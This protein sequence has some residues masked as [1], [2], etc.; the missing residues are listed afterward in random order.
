IGGDIRRDLPGP[1]KQ[2]EQ[3][4]KDWIKLMDRAVGTKYVTSLCSGTELTPV[5]MEIDKILKSC[6]LSLDRYLQDKREYFPRFFFVSTTVLLDILSKRTDPSSIKNNLCIIFDAINDIEF[7]EMDRRIIVKIMQCKSEGNYKDIQIVDLKEYFVKCEGKIED[8]LNQLVLHMQKSIKAIFQKAYS[9]YRQLY[10]GE[11]TAFS[12]YTKKYISQV[13]I[14]G[15]M[16]YGTKKL[17]EFVQRTSIEKG[18]TYKKKLVEARN[19]GNPNGEKDPVDLEFINIQE[20]L[21]VLCREPHSNK[22]EVVKLETLIIIHV[23]SRDIFDFILKQ[24]DHMVTVTDYDWLKQSRVYWLVSHQTCIIN[25]TDVPFEYG[26]EFLGAKERL[27]ITELTDKCYITLAQALGMNYGGA[28]AGPA[29]TGKTE[30]VKDMG[31]TMG[32][33]VLVTNC[34]PEH[35]YKNMVQIFKGLCRAGAW[36]CFDEFNRIFLDVLSVVA[37]IVSSIQDAFKQGKTIFKFPDVDNQLTDCALVATTAY[38]IT[39]NPGYAGRQELPENLKVLFRG[40]TMML[41][42]RQAII[43]VKLSSYGFTDIDD[44]SK[45][46]AKLYTLCEDQLSK[47]KHYDFGLRNIL[48]VLRAAGNEKKIIKEKE[49]EEKLI[50][51]ALRDMNESKF[52]PDDVEL[53][54]SL[55]ED[56]FSNIKNVGVRQY[57]ELE[58][59][60]KEVIIRK[61]LDYTYPKWIKKVIQTYETSLV[62]HGFMIIGDTGTGKSTILEC[63]TEAMSEWKGPTNK[64]MKW[65]IH[66]MNPK[67]IENE[68]MFIQ[69]KLDTY[70][71]GTF[72]M[73]WKRCNENSPKGQNWLVCDGPID[74]IWIESLNTVLDD[75]KILTLSNNDRIGMLDSCRMVFEAENLRNATLATVSRAGMIY[76]TEGDIGY[77]PYINSWFMKNKD[78][79]KDQRF[80]ETELRDLIEKRYL[81]EQMILELTVNKSLKL[82]MNTSWLIR[83]KNFLLLIETL[84]QKK[85]YLDKSYIEKVVIFAFCWS[86]GGLLELDQRKIFHEVLVKKA[87]APIPEIEDDKTIFDYT[88]GQTWEGWETEV[89][90]LK[91]NEIANF[92][93][94]IIPTMDSTRAIALIEKVGKMKIDFNSDRCHPVL[95]LGD[96]GTAK[97]STV[98]L[99]KKLRFVADKQVLKRVN[100]SSAT[101]P[102]NFQETVDDEI[103]KTGNEYVPFFDKQMLVLVDDISMPLVNKW[104]DQMTLE[105]VRQLLE[106]GGYY[107]IGETEN[108]GNM[109]KVCRLTYIGA[110]NHPKGGKND[111]PN[112]LK[113]QFYIFNMTLPN[114]Q[115]VNDIYGKILRLFF[116]PKLYGDLINFASGLTKLTVEILSRVKSKFQPT[117]IKFHYNFN[118]R[119][120]SR[121]FQGIFQ[122]ANSDSLKNSQAKYQ[123]KQ[124]VYLIHLWRHEVNRVMNDK[125][126]DEQDKLDFKA[127]LESTVIDVLGQEFSDSVSENFY[128]CD[129]LRE[130][131]Q[132]PESG[133]D[134]YNKAYEMIKT[135]DKLKEVTKWFM[136]R[137][138]EEKKRKH[139]NLVL[140]ED[141]LKYLIRITRVINT[142]QGSIM[143]V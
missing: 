25:I 127:I 61:K 78:I 71:L 21:A 24:K 19:S 81:T 75:N 120:L 100:F 28:P 42:D 123:M 45:K 60:L 77:S 125:L 88:I 70:I 124:E 68:Y 8:W 83:I 113:R 86:I 128:F 26:Y 82:C 121:T 23:H 129:Y 52:T 97:T 115:S 6:E 22:L 80:K 84:L 142:N 112:R 36:G 96:A 73:L 4:D 59:K 111:I 62:R 90:E 58:G 33:F 55:I 41:P 93:N 79:F 14:F 89:S 106:Q 104:G 101:N 132:D 46:F 29:G 76:I 116:S 63:L 131:T 65:K 57:K 3:A 92:S 114:T 139:V 94:L 72:T 85:E 12:D 91:A 108:R 53:F 137:L 126:R 30:T 105:L 110:M 20:Q 134:L 38:F 118:M 13:T 10:D 141:C 119:D 51:I 2:F 140:F 37:T 15:L 32:V 43:R 135:F 109:K 9:D 54:K 11:L 47:Q 103:E 40:V 143:L 107:L 117:P 56:V 98:L 31:R 99:Y 102:V 87:K 1:T 136:D 66:R 69:K 18:D 7:S 133:R 27:S 48:S 50:Y 16:I 130:I 39:M 49:E 44:L 67:A 74:S 35:R 5:L 64:E 17:E 122:S 138:S 95:L 34:A